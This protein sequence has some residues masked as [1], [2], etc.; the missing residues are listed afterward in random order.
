MQIL[1]LARFRRSLSEFVRFSRSYGKPNIMTYWRCALTLPF[2]GAVLGASPLMRSVYEWTERTGTSAFPL[3]GGRG[4]RAALRNPPRIG[5]NKL[6]SFDSPV[7][8]PTFA[9]STKH[10]PSMNPKRKN[11]PGGRP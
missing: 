3:Q 10:E 9:T 11:D 8:I 7:W 1:K 5:Q 2:W 4:S 6:L